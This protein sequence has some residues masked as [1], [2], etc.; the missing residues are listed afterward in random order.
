MSVKIGKNVIEVLTTGMYTNPL[1]MFRE[2]VQNSADQIDTAVEQG[3]LSERTAGRIFIKIDDRDKVI[4]VEDNATGIIAS[5]TFAT[6]T[7][8]AAS[9]KDRKKKKGFRGIGRLGGLAYCD[10]LIFETSAKGERTK[11]I[12]KWDS[13]LLRQILSDQSNKREAHEVVG[14]VTEFTQI[15]CEEP[16]SHYFRVKL[17]RVT[18]PAILD[19]EDVRNYL[20]MVAPVQISNKFLFRPEVQAQFQKQNVEVDEYL[21]YV[22]EQE[23]L[24]PYTSKIYQ[25]NNG[26]KKAID[27]VLDVKFIEIF[28]GE[29]LLATGWYGITSALQQIPS[30]NLVRGIRLRKGNIQIGES[31]ALQ[32]LWKDRRFHFYFVGELHAISPRLIPNGR[33]DYFDENDALHVFEE[34]LYA[35]FNTNLYRLTHDASKINAAIKKLDKHEELKQEFKTK[36]TNG[37]VSKKEHLELQKRVE[38]SQEDVEKAKKDLDKIKSK[39]KENPAL[40]KIFKNVVGEKPDKE[41]HQ[42]PIDIP[43]PVWQTDKLSKLSKKERKIVSEI[44]EVVRNVLT[45]DL[46]NNLILKIEEKFK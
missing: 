38:R 3:V 46:A 44:Y 45:P 10:E 34:E 27:D 32:N 5:D 35:F 31:D 7:S 14:D 23:I 39:T 12:L 1:F 21:V 41:E 28:D 40:E 43:I 8:I 36:S 29:E 6:L 22:N 13:K 11:S 15:E 4:E 24:K 2:Y 18:N 33:R 42:E 26:N 9:E 25:Q 30:C 17:N 16:E 20:A 37:F 19:I